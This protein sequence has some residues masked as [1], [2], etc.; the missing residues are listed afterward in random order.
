M[1]CAS[2]GS[3]NPAG[4]KFYIECA[5]PLQKRCPNCGAE[6]LPRAKFCGGCATPLAPPVAS[7][8]QVEPNPQSIKQRAKSDKRGKAKSPK[9]KALRSSAEVNRGA[10]E[11]ERRQL[12]VMFCDLVGSTPLAEKL[13]PA[14]APTAVE[15][16]AAFRMIR[17]ADTL[18]LPRIWQ[19]RLSVTAYDAAISRWRSA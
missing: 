12:T 4:A 5:A 1:H 9:P 7:S 14:R 17:Y 10:P 3:E 8:L 6:N 15:D 19:L 11:A 13:D 16:F 18:F 2:C